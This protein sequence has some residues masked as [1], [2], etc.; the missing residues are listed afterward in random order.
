MNKKIN[1]KDITKEDIKEALQDLLN[2][3]PKTRQ[4]KV[5][6]IGQASLDAFNKAMEER[7]VIE[8]ITKKI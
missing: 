7:L 1:H 3:K 4:Y 6:A 2:K 5:Y 8:G